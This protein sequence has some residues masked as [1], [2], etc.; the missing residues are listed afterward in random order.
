MAVIWFG[1][2]SQDIDEKTAL[3]EN[4]SNKFNSNRSPVINV[5]QQIKKK[6]FERH[7]KIAAYL[8]GSYSRRIPNSE[9]KQK[10]I[11]I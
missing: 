4:N 8:N 7:L 6:N 1:K 2:K 9:I 5:L 11:E 3:K 10:S